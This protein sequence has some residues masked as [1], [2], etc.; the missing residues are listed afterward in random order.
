MCPQVHK[1]NA[2]CNAAQTSIACW[3][4]TATRAGQP[5]CAARSWGQRT[6][7]TPP[8]GP[9]EQAP[10]PVP[11]A[12]SLPLPRTLAAGADLCGFWG[13]TNEEL[14]ARWIAAGALM[15]FARNHAD[16]SSPYQVSGRG[17]LFYE[18]LALL[19]G[20]G[21]SLQGCMRCACAAHAGQGSR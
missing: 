13:E 5:S 2:Q 19:C 21:R 10:G 11:P 16:F 1:I 7:G 20:A 14:C 3:L 18:F 9:A 8:A 15:P 6:W 12:R 4:P 17:S